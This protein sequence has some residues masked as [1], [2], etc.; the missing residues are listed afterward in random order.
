MMKRKILKIATAAVMI[1]AAT[2]L[3]TLGS[4]PA[5]AAALP[6]YKLIVN[7]GH[8]ALDMTA[9]GINAPAIISNSGADNNWVFVNG[10][11]WTN[12]NGQNVQ[13]TE[14][15]HAGTDNCIIYAQDVFEIS[16]CVPGNTDELFWA[17][18]TGSTTNGNPNYW[19]INEA[20]SEIVGDY[21]YITAASLTNGAELQADGPGFGGQ[22]SW[23][24]KCSANC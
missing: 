9:N 15:Q 13:V 2:G 4:A 1:A 17:D 11:S 7:S 18:P 5:R 19:Y 12:L 16:G 23:N 21:I 8:T 24:R 10:Q 6:S 20:T 3:A 14:I 22:A